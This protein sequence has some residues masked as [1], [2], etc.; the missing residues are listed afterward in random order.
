MTTLQLGKSIGQ[1]PLRLGLFLIPLLLACFAVCQMAQAVVPAPDG[2]YAG[3]NTAEGQSALLSLTSGTYNTA[4]GLFSLRS[5]TIGNFNTAVGAGTLVSNTGGTGDQGHQNTATG[6]GA[7]FSN[8]SGGL[9]TANG[10]FA[11]FSN[12]TGGVNTAIGASALFSNTTANFNTATGFQALAST[13]DGGGNT[14]T[15]YQALINNTH[16]FN[17]TSVGFQAI[18]SNISGFGNTAIGAGALVNNTGEGNTAL[19]NL[20]GQNLTTGD[21]NICIGNDG[22]A[23]DGGVIRIGAP[24]INA[25][26]IAGISGQ[27]ASGGAQVFVTSD[28][29]LGTETSSARFKDEIKPMGSDSEAILALRPVSFRYK[30]EIDPQRIPQFGLVAEEVEEV[31]PDLVVRDTR[32]RPYSVRYEQVNAMLLNEFLKEHRKVEE[33]QATITQLK[34]N[35]GAT[36]AQLTARL[37]QQ[38]SQIQKVSAQLE[39]A[40]PVPQTV[41][42]SR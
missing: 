32:G 1:W 14:A 22:V 42:N 35:F 4:L 8:I 26:Y 18:N 25:T 10:A 2:G 33:Q 34:K 31:S 9:N 19:G 5:N 21:G 40:K 24:F 6:A 36:I 29:K 15:G 3:G 23:G 41:L 7:L 28:G 27:T 20:A 16:G 37:D 12:N 17:N 38:A 30:K 39:V 13:T 11:L